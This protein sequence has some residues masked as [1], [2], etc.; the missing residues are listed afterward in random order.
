[1]KPVK[2]IHSALGTARIAGAVGVGQTAVRNALARGVFPATWYLVVLSE[3][4]KA[5]VPCPP[6]AFSF[7]AWPKADQRVPAVGSFE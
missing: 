6:E 4:R 5:G 7:T 1:M 3:C 2:Q